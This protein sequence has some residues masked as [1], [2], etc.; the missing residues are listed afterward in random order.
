MN[1]KEP[2]SSVQPEEPE[3]TPYIPRTS[4]QR[5]LAWVALAVVLFGLFG[6]LYW[7]IHF[8]P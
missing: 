8:V 3:K 6:T 5:A 2:I 7:M 4:G 1:E